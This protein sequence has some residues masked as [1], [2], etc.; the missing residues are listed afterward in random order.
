MV[1]IGKLVWL[2]HDSDKL[3]LLPVW[4]TGKIVAVVV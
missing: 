3:C 4:A 1:G 2:V